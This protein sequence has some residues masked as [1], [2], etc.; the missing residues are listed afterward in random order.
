[1][2]TLFI[3]RIARP[4]RA[5]APERLNRPRDWLRYWIGDWYHHY[6]SKPP[7]GR[8]LAAVVPSRE[9]WSDRQLDRVW[10]LLHLT[11][12]QSLVVIGALFLKQSQSKRL[13]E[14]WQT[15]KRVLPVD[16]LD[17]IV[18]S[19]H[20]MTS[21]QEQSTVVV[22]CRQIETGSLLWVVQCLDSVGLKTGNTMF[23]TISFADHCSRFAQES[24]WFV[25]FS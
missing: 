5:H 14:I 15:I 8:V 18:W 9:S 16:T 21:F 22:E 19:R 6:H 11:D 24:C 12:G 4:I 10:L 25:L 13:R 3:H 1:M 23:W 17:G 20:Y 7:V 2:N